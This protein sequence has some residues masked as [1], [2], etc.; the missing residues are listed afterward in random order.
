[1]TIPVG[2]DGERYSPDIK[3]KSRKPEP[4]ASV[5]VDIDVNKDTNGTAAATSNT[6]DGSTESDV[7]IAC[8]QDKVEGTPSSPKEDKHAAQERS[9]SPVKK[10][11]KEQN[12][13]DVSERSTT[14]NSA[15]PV[16]S[17]DAITTEEKKE[18]AQEETTA[19]ST[20]RKY[21]SRVALGLELSVKFAV[22]GS[23]TLIRAS[24][25]AMQKQ[26]YGSDPTLGIAKLPRPLM[27]KDAIRH[28]V[29]ISLQYVGIS[30]PKAC[31]F[32]PIGGSSRF[33]G[34]H[35]LRPRV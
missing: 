13:P 34:H 23:I 33:G 20:R 11:I 6:P 28:N 14:T 17:D 2:F 1:M 26:P 25:D 12:L 4:K 15:S 22:P 35:L 27:D 10:E 7:T 29:L 16:Q 18:T 5:D 31:I 19:P 3:L 30:Q 9:P 21:R 8:P 32:E 24:H